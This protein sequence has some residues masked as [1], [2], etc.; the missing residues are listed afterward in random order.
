MKKKYVEPGILIKVLI[1]S[2]VQVVIHAWGYSR[3]D[4][5]KFQWEYSKIIVF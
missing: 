4:V 1:W 5:E 2:D 3:A